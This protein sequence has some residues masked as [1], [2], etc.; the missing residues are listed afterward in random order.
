MTMLV[1]PFDDLAGVS[2][3]KDVMIGWIYRGKADM[4][5]WPGA[6][7]FIRSVW[8]PPMLLRSLFWAIALQE[9]RSS[10]RKPPICK[11]EPSRAQ[12]KPFAPV[13]LQTS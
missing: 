10:D 7:S 4:F 12:A 9:A 13:S 11:N 5:I 6:L 8:P 3:Y 1:Y 2:K